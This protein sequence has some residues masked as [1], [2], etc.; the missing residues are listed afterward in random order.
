MPGECG[1][2]H[3]DHFADRPELSARLQA[4]DQFWRECAPH[5]TD[6]SIIL[7]TIE[8]CVVGS[9]VGMP[10]SM[11][12]SFATAMADMAAERGEPQVPMGLIG[13]CEHH[14]HRCLALVLL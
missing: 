14:I 4:A 10:A 11:C 1:Q 5:P 3:A 2:A 8:L 7:L 13:S 9:V 6:P 12:W